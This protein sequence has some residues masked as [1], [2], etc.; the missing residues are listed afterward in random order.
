MAPKR[1]RRKLPPT[2]YLGDVSVFKTL[3]ICKNFTPVPVL[4]I[5]LCLSFVKP[6]PPRWMDIVWQNQ[7]SFPAGSG[8]AGSCFCSGS[9][10]WTVVPFTKISAP[11]CALACGTWEGS[12][13]F[14]CIP[15]HSGR[16]GP[17]T[18]VGHLQDL[19]KHWQ[20]L[21]YHHQ[22][23]LCNFKELCESTGVWRR[24]LF[25]RKAE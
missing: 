22:M 11:T 12:K 2:W 20:Q 9:D 18:N 4:D 17:N 24:C 23:A 25:C 15:S 21:S 19:L 1:Q 7:V 16:T 6:S 14:T 13:A 8:T 5:I 3:Q 10:M